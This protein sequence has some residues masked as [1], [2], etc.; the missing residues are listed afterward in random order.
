MIGRMDKEIKVTKNIGC[1]EVLEMALQIEQVGYDFYKTLAIH[2][3]NPA[4]KDLY[5]HLAEEE[6][7][8]LA[9]FKAI[10][11]SL[12]EINVAEIKNWSELA[13]YF[14]A[15]LDTNVLTGLPEKNA[16]IP[17]LQDEIGAIHISI[18]LEKDTILFLQEMRNWVSTEDQEKIN[19]LIE[20]ERNHILLL[21][22]IKRQI[23]PS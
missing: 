23:A 20:D 1:N 15:L 9:N 19:K 11:H 8:H 7:K 13:L 17:E 2:F 3:A 18:S 16:L 6:R 5:N 21:L 14:T 22:N 10:R 12:A 4:L